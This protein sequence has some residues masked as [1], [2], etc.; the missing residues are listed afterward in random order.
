MSVRSR[1]LL[2]IAALA[3]LTSCSST[4]TLT[5]PDSPT[6]HDLTPTASASAT[7]SADILLPQFVKLVQGA[8]EAVPV[9]RDDHTAYQATTDGTLSQPA[10]PTGQVRDYVVQTYVYADTDIKHANP[11]SQVEALLR[12]EGLKFAPWTGTL[13]GPSTAMTAEAVTDNVTVSINY[14]PKQLQILAKLPCLPGQ[15][16]PIAQRA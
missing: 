16:L 12:A 15:R 8:V 11:T 6:A 7:Q 9:L 5:A 10:C 1:S 3:L 13:S 14:T 4:P 2:C